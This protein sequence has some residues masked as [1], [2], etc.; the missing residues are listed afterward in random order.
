ML[1]RRSLRAVPART[2]ERTCPVCQGS[3]RRSAPLKSAL[4]WSA[5]RL[6]AAGAAEAREDRVRRRQKIPLHA[7]PMPAAAKEEE[8]CTAPPRAQRRRAAIPPPSGGPGLR[9]ADGCRHRPALRPR[10]FGDPGGTRDSHRPPV[11][12]RHPA[13]SGSWPSP[14]PC[15]CRNTLRQ[16]R[17]FATRQPP[18]TPG[19]RSGTGGTQ[20]SQACGLNGGNA[21][22][23][24]VPHISPARNQRFSGGGAAWSLPAGAGS[25]WRGIVHAASQTAPSSRKP[26]SSRRSRPIPGM[27][28]AP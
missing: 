28:P 16:F 24:T 20:S 25:P 1:L 3:V 18:A 26:S 10:R 6:P 17:K 14:S 19:R 12:G 15:S 5:P 23:H 4:P 21:T 7:G 22:D 11:D 2:A 9:D 27:W 8:G 13:G